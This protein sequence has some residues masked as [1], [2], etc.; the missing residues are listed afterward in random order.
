M[1]KL[2]HDRKI[3]YFQTAVLAEPS[4]HNSCRPDQKSYNFFLYKTQPHCV[5]LVGKVEKVDSPSLSRAKLIPVIF[6]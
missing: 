2:T 6:F 3:F 5:G 4:D 1:S